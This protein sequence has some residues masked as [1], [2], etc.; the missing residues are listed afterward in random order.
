MGKETIESGAFTA[1]DSGPS[2]GEHFVQS[3][4][5]PPEGLGVPMGLDA[6]G[7][8]A[9]SIDTGP[10]MLRPPCIFTRVDRSLPR[11][12]HWNPLTI[13]PG[14]AAAETCRPVP[15]SKTRKGTPDTTAEQQLTR[16]SS[17]LSVLICGQRD[18][19]QHEPEGSMTL[20]SRGRSGE[21]TAR[22]TASPSSTT[23]RAGPLPLL[24]RA[25]NDCWHPGT[26][27]FLPASP[28]L[29]RRT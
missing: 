24:L 1:L 12:V 14:A 7:Y 2:A 19:H 18:W 11:S 4:D 5:E 13:I 16:S 21:T 3:S 6:S 28:W 29:P 17:G 8:S 22:A 23:A 15:A 9:S 25:T 20:A 26:W 10:R 27:L